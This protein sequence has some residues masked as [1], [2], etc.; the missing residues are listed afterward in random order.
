MPALLKIVIGMIAAG[1]A[2]VVAVISIVIIVA[3]IMFIQDHRRHMKATRALHL[4]GWRKPS[5][6]EKEEK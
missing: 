4:A 6:Q 3:G 5:I 2:L 1:L